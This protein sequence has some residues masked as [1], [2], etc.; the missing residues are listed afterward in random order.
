MSNTHFKKVYKSD[1]LGVSDLE[2]M[3]EEGHTLNFTIKE[4]RQELQVSIAGRK[5]DHNI[6]YFV[7]K[8]KPMVVN[9]TNGTIIQRFAPGK[10]PFIEHWKMMPITLFIDPEVKMKGV[11]VGGVRIRGIQPK[12]A[13]PK[14]VFTEANFEAAHEAGATIESIKV[15]RLVSPEIEVLFNEYKIN[16]S[17]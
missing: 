15:S 1:H 4:V 13:K 12:A 17:K 14:Q 2:I 5:G 8:I 9:S 16:K 10:S 11:K 7:E 3:L 6:A